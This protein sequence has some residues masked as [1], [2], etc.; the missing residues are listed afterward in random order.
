MSF[1]KKIGSLFTPQG[2]PDEKAYWIYVQ[3]GE[4]SEKIRARIDL[5]NDLSIEY[6]EDGEKD[7]YICRKTILG[8]ARCFRRLEV[9]LTFDSRRKL[10]DREIAGG[11]FI[12]AEDF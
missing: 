1:F 7:I 2:S 3:C 8:K 9:T 4:C 6:G 12:S 5:Y 11:A 10:L